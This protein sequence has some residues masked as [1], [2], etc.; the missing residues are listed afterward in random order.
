MGNDGRT[1]IDQQREGLVSRRQELCRDLEE[2]ALSNVPEK[3]SARQ[4]RRD[5]RERIAHEL[6]EIETQIADL[7][8]DERNIGSMEGRE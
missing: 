3:I 4:A 7:N 8:L 5:R 1:W 2:L 6:D